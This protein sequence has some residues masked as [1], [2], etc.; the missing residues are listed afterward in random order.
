ME[1]EPDTSNIVPQ[2]K[3]VEAQQ[4]DHT[5]SKSD[6]GKKRKEIDTRS[7][8]WEHFERVKDASGVTIKGRCIYCGK[9][10]NAHSKLH[11][12]SSL[13]GHIL[14]CTKNPHSKDKR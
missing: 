5:D 8:A 14:T 2:E 6:V 11:G 13:R 9:Q 1:A 12:T 10:I 4:K 3:E 7:K